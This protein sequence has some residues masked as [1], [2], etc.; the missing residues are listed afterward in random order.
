MLGKIKGNKKGQEMSITTLLLIVLGVVV[1]VVVI[2]AV[3]GVF[4]PIFSG[5]KLAPG[6]FSSFVKACN[7]Y[8]SIGSVTDYCMF[9]ELTIDNKKEYLNCDAS[10]VQNDPGFTSKGEISCP[11]PDE[12]MKVK[13]VSLISSGLKNPIVNG[14]ACGSNY[15]CK[16]DLNGTLIPKGST[17]PPKDNNK[18]IIADT[19]TQ[20]RTLT[21]GFVSSGAQICCV[22]S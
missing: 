22:K 9:R 5:L 20:T 3:S 7:A 1:V 18:A 13:C 8:V 15:D 6:D 21:E 14:A 11:N 10:K 16:Q 19:Q 4:G 2:M 17:C 12:S